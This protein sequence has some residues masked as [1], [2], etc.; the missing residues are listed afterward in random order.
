MTTTADR[1]SRK[2]RP[3]SRRRGRP[4]SPRRPGPRSRRRGGAGDQRLRL[5]QAAPET[6]RASDAGRGRDAG[7]GRASASTALATPLDLLL[8]DAGAQPAAPLPPGHVRRQVHRRARA[9]PPHG[10]RARGRAGL[11][12]ARVGLG[13]SELGP[14][15]KDRRFTEE[16]WAR[17]P[18]LQA[19]PAG[20]P[21]RGRGR[22]RP[23]RRRRARLGRRPADGLH[24][25]QP[26][27]GRGPQQQPVPQPQG[28]QADA[29]HRRRQPRRGRPALRARL[30][31]RPA[32]A[33]DG[34]ARRVRGR[35][36]HRGDAR[37]GGAAHRRLRA[38]PVHPADPQGPLGAAADR[39]ADD[40]QV[41]RDRPRRAAQPGRAPGRRTASRSS[42]S[43]GATPTPGTPT[44]AWTPTARR[45]SRR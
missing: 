31:H 28:D 11:E 42:A 6:G 7:L 16:A 34:R 24:R 26:R 39:A 17:N 35:R 9:P 33:V 13:R 40:Q 32:G 15:A 45:S 30:R 1:A 12:L 2:P 20:L 21:R 10:R 37:R 5:G 44:G 18:A 29:R 41:L 3:R 23:G 36:R 14:D 25:R 19:H 8:A 22:A 4:R 27:R 43:P 38:D